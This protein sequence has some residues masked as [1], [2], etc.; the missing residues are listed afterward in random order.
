MVR[1]AGMAMSHSS[2]GMSFTCCMSRKPTAT[3]AGDAAWD[4]TIVVSGVRNKATTKKAA[5]NTFASPVRA[6]SPTPA[7]DSMKQVF[8]EAEA[9]P[10]ALAAGVGEGART[11]LANVF[12]AAVFVV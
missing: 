9:I 1:N 3:N 4:G 5:V 2:H 7:A 6:P 12:T 8:D 11:G 10:P